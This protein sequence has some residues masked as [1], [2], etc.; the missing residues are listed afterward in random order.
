[1]SRCPV[2]VSGKHWGAKPGEHYQC[3]YKAGHVERGRQLGH[4]YAEP[5]PDI[6]G[7]AFVD[8]ERLADHELRN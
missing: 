3:I 7:R 4:A 2:T 5:G 1:M 6:H 8:D